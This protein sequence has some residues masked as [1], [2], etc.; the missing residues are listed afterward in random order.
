MATADPFI[1]TPQSSKSDV[2]PDLGPASNDAVAAQSGQAGPRSGPTSAG[3]RS[4][5]GFTLLEVLVG[6]AILA[7]AAVVL[8]AAYVNTLGAHE[9]VAR[10]AAAGSGMDY[11]REVIF[12]E[13][14]RTKVEEGGHLALPDNR[15]MDW[16][17]VIEEAPVPDLFKVVVRGRITGT[18]NK[19]AEE[20]E[21]TLMLLRP[22][23]SDAGE[24]EKLRVEWDK[25]REDTV[26]R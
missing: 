22:T 11:L 4:R 18:G 23:W 3:D 15:Q 2:G 10:R 26:R 24:R 9:A 20:F 13:T 25:L 5:R 14:E 8:G 1:Y 6:I 12:N 19:D 7:M 16:E 17:A 21:Q